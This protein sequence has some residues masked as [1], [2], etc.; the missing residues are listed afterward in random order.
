[1]ILTELD[2]LIQEQVLWK[3]TLSAE[4]E[5]LLIE[6]EEYSHLFG[7]EADLTRENIKKWLTSLRT[8]VKELDS[9][10]VVPSDEVF[11]SNLGT[12]VV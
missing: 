11:E 12:A 6:I 5:D 2:K 8:F 7:Q 4:I 9:D 3:S 10:Y 1:T